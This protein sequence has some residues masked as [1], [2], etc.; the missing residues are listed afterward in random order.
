MAVLA[1]PIQAG[2][3]GLFKG[4]ATGAEAITSGKWAA[5]L[6]T[7]SMTFTT[8]SNQTSTVTNT[9]TVVL[10]GVS[11][12]VTISNPVSGSP[13]FNLFVCGVAWSSGK[14][15]GGAGTAVGGTFFKNSTT[16]VSSAVVPA[17]GG[18]V[19]LQVE[20]AL[21]TSSTTVTLGTSITSATQLRAAIHTNQ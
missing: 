21:E 3:A 5:T 14:C 8:N 16:T 17:V 2:A 18:H 10:V 20:P 7:T 1:V 12:K 11:Y 6:S 13:T 4:S 9:G 15:S 19:Y